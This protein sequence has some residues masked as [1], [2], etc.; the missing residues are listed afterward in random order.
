[1]TKAAIYCRISQDR[2][3]EGAGV[4]RQQEDALALAAQLDWEVVE[5]YVDNDISATSGKPRPAY[6]K[7]LADVEAGK[8]QAIVAWHADR[9][10]RRAVDL[11]ELVDVCKRHNV[12]IATVR[13]GTIDLTTPTG[14][15]VAGLLAQVATYEGEAK[16][17]RWRRSVTQRRRAGAVPG[18]GQRMY[19]YTRDGQVVDAEAEAARGMADDL[20]AGVSLV[21]IANR[22]NAEGVTNA[23]GAIWRSTTLRQYLMNPRLAG[24]S[25]LNG[26]IVGVG[27]WEPIIDADTWE[28]VRAILAARGRGSK[29]PRIALLPG[30][31]LCGECETPLVSAARTDATKGKVRMYRC[32]K[33][34]GYSGC[35]KISADAEPVEAVVEE[36]AKAR[37]EDGRVRQRVTELTAST[38]TAAILTEIASLEARLLELETELEE[39][40]VPVAAITRAMGA[41]KD[42]L[43]DCQ[44][45]LAAAQPV[46][47]P[48]RGGAWPTNLQARR[49]LVEI[50]LVDR[51]VYLDRSR[52]HRGF[53]PHR[54]RIDQLG[55]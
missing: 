12:Q 46:A 53:D 10:Y 23:R 29:G 6:R 1:M 49:R 25:T 36:Y 32:P 27:Q 21:G 38:D 41:T 54:V 14:R 18:T 22:L 4:T 16:S 55:D 20:L 45:R 8:V 19:G 30:I 40:G 2:T 11:G 17:D 7:M 28:T 26:E 34:P 3:G 48:G 51:L 13:A 9:L 15:L 42:R 43:E 33:R 35:G 37:L 39:P 44:R 52:P 5:V 50:A 24:H 47:L 31:I